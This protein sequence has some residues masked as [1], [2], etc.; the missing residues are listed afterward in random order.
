MRPVSSELLTGYRCFQLSHITHELSKFMEQLCSPDLPERP[1]TPAHIVKKPLTRTFSTQTPS[2]TLV[3]QRTQ[4]DGCPHA[5]P[6][7]PE[8]GT[9]A[10]PPSSLS[11]ASASP[12]SESEPG[13][14]DYTP[15]SPRPDSTEPSH[16][17]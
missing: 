14:P 15:T 5:E 1:F 7:C 16:F 4:T 13:S 12:P 8:L 17:Y 9:P 2:A 10:S 3:D 6:C 11:P